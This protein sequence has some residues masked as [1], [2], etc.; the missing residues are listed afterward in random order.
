[1]QAADF[2]PRGGFGNCPLVALANRG[3][4]GLHVLDR[5]EGEEQTS[6][7]AVGTRSSVR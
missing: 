1:M 3:L 5:P 2:S 7:E 6:F 4:S